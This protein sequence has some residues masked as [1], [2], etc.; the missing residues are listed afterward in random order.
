MFLD[1]ILLRVHA[2]GMSALR[3]PPRLLLRRHVLARL[4]Q[5]WQSLLERLGRSR[6]WNPVLRTFWPGNARFHGRKV[7]IEHVSVLGFWRGWRME[8]ALLLV[9]R[10]DGG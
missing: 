4:Q 2:G 9:V 10:L 6:Q 7:E 1:R 5:S 3:L 8:Q